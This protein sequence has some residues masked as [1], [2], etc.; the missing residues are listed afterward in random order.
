MSSAALQVQIPMG[1]IAA[2]SHFLASL[3]DKCF[4]D[5]STQA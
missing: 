1:M 4:Q 3:T 5:N 2:Q